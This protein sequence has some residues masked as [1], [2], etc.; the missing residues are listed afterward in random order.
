MDAFDPA[1][2]AASALLHRIGLRTAPVVVVGL[3]YVGLALAESLAV[4]G[5]PVTGFDTDPARVAALNGGLCPLPHL[6]SAALRGMRAA[7]FRA[8]SDPACVHHA[9]IAVIC[10]PTPLDDRR[11]PDLGAVEAAAGA[12]AARMRLGGLVVM[13]STIHPHGTQEALGTALRARGL[14]PGRDVFMAFSPERESPGDLACRGTGIPRLLGADDDIS[15]RLGAAFYRAAGYEVHEVSSI[16]TA[17]AAKLVENSFRLV[18]VALA[19]EFKTVFRGLGIDVQEVIAAAA[20]KPFGFMPFLPGPGAG[21]HCIPVDPLYLAWKARDCGLDTPLITLSAALNAAMP[22]RIAEELLS[23]LAAR[24]GRSPAQGRILV[25]G[26]AYKRNVGDLR[27]SP[28]LALL[29]HL[30]AAGVGVR[31]HDAWAQDWPADVAPHRLASLSADDL[32]GFD[33]GVIATDHDGPDYAE[34][35]RHV[36]VLADARGAARRLGLDADRVVPV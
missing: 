4:A 15:R 21:G 34:V 23:L 13:E 5:F 3:G 20:T 12:I 18:N 28:A 7:G 33:I 25:L 29:R 9:D 27:E 26:L 32:A 22:A 11:L 36:G 6:S 10:V 8:S 31:W 19:N 17:E 30:V 24:F 1:E 2:R 35:A 16:A 14:K